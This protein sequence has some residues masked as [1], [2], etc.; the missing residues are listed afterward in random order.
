MKPKPAKSGPHEEPTAEVSAL[1]ETLHETGRRLEDLTGGEVDAV[2]NRR[3]QTVLL[4]R[5]QDQLRYN[6]A[7]RQAAILNALPANI[8]L[9]G[10]QGLII[11]VNNA[12]RR[13]GRVNEA[14]APGHGVGVNYLEVCDNALGDDAAEA[15]QV[16][17]GIRSVLS[18]ALKTFSIEYPCHSLTAQ[19]WFLLTVTPLADDSPNG[20]VIMHLDVTTEKLAKEHLQ[21]SELR[22]RQLADAIRD[23]FFLIDAD[24]GRVLFVSP[25]YADIYGRSCDSAYA[26]PQAW[27][28]AVHP[29]DRASI[30]E[31]YKK[32]MSE[33][34]FDFECRIVRSDNS[35]RWI[36]VRGFAVH[37]AAGSTVRIAGVAADITLRKEADDRI[38]RLNRVYAVLSGIN[39]LIVRVR[40]RDELFRE[41]CRI[42]VEEGG[43]RMTWI[44]IVDRSE[45]KIVPVASAGVDAGFMEEVRERLSLRDDA[46]VG[47]GAPAVAVR[48]KRAVVVNNVDGHPLIHYKSAHVERGVHSLA[49]LPM[50][51]ADEPVAVLGLHAAEAGYFDEAEMVLLTQLAG[52]IAFA[53]DHLDK[54]ARLDYL[55]Y[56]DVLTGLANRSLFLERLAQ[57]VR[58]AVS[59]KHKLAVFLL[60]LERFKN[61]N[62]SLGQLAGDALLKQVAQWLTGITGDANLLARVGSDH[63][64]VVLPEIQ[65]ES[66][67][68]RLLE[69]AIQS[70]LAHPF[71]LGDAVLRISFKVGVA[72]FPN[73]GP[74]ADSLFRNAEAALKRAKAS[75]DQYLFYA[76]KMTAMVA[77]K[78]T[79]ENELRQALDNEEFV[80]HYQPKVNLARGTLTGAEA[81]I[82]WHDPRT[83]LVP[84]GRFIPVLEETGMIHEVGR[85]AMR[86]AIGDYLRWRAAGLAAV[87]I[88]VNVSP[89]QLRHRAFTAEVGQAVGI[90]AR[91]AA[92]LE[93][94]ITESLIMADV[95][96]SIVALKAIRALGI[97]IAIDDFGTGFS[98]LSYLAKLPV[99]TLKI[100]RSFVT[101]MTAAPAGLAL[102]STIIDLAHSLKL[103]VVA[104]G[105]ETEEQARLL[106][107]SNCDEM[108][109][110]LFSKPVP[111]EI[112]EARFLVP[113]TAGDETGDE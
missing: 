50:L 37:D 83:G 73:D 36:E 91:A 80:L 78:L 63:F 43:F 75:G 52:D 38:R 67:A 102:V 4:R 96:H 17:A 13:F 97:T 8:A 88:A 30:D 24:S 19:R 47:H 58:S 48:E 1:I 112:F 104:E 109:G 62:D 106:R 103:N 29:D 89:L 12:W 5:A 49:I 45:M 81:L 93:L 23:I 35:I 20:A 64:A 92:G 82:R 7:V 22:F 77:R 14:Q 46:P 65:H 56:Y 60:D 76:P 6:E 28:E 95:R 32:G 15:H 33:G 94:E 26:S 68:A 113:R 39:A 110:F 25:A 53:I 61:I 57:Y 59:G 44:G 27:T 86:Q 99:D 34:K 51:I 16:A 107:A 40:D 21:A 72:L 10:S 74:D 31:K 69:H 11:S 41:A 55:A 98:S 2:T 42:A 9:L 3:G 100:D 66:D 108:Q 71:R 111:C 84:P 54:Q 18:G 70:F 87:R 90:D 101:D 85:R 79:L 105:V